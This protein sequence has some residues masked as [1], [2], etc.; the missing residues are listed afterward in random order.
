V[1]STTDAPPR[2]GITGEPQPTY[3][4]KPL[5][6]HLD[7]AER[8]LKQVEDV[9]P[10]F[11]TAVRELLV[12]TSAILQ[13]RNAVVH[14]VWS[15]SRSELARGWRH[16]SPGN[17]VAAEPNAE[18]PWT[19]W[20]EFTEEQFVDLTEELDALVDRLREQIALSGAVSQYLAEKRY[21]LAK[22]SE[23]ERADRP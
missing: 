11:V 3:A 14:S 9:F 8:R 12:D 21:E 2:L 15:G 18:S 13:Q 7:E 17:R 10:D 4:G 6:S 16:I 1:S 20:T 19:E 22:R 23:S 5:Q